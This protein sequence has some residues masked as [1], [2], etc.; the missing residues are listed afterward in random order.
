MP[1][2]K[3]DIFKE[4][5]E[6]ELFILGDTDKE[7]AEILYI[8]SSLTPLQIKK[9][10]EQWGSGDIKL[11][12]IKNW[13]NSENWLKLRKAYTKT[14]DEKLQKNVAEAQADIDADGQAAIRDKYAEISAE[15]MNILHQKIEFCKP[16][17]GHAAIVKPIELMQMSIAMKNASEVHFRALGI[18]ELAFIDPT[19]GQE[20]IRILTVEDIKRLEDKKKK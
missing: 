9:R 10:M 11:N 17:H 1:R 20:G 19:V 18:A 16:R 6:K 4:Y 15:L 14:Y 12:T 2:S 5:G 8:R 7:R 3:E 13:A